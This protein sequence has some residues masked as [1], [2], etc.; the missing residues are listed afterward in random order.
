MMDASKYL[1]RIGFSGST[2]VSL[3]CLAELMACHQ[4]AVPFENLDVFLKR[5]KVLEVEVLFERIVDEQRGGWCCE[6]NGLFAWLLQDLGFTVRRISASNFNPEKKEF[7]MMY[8][9]MALVV[10][11]GE[12]EYLTDVG[13]G[14]IH[15]HYLP[16]RLSENS[17][18]KQPGGLYKLEKDESHWF[19]LHRVRDVVGHHREE[20]NRIMSEETW[21]VV[22]RFDTQAKELEEFQERCDQYQVDSSVMLS[23]MPIC[24]RKAQEGLVVNA[25]TGQRLTTITFKE[26]TDVRT[27]ETD[28]SNA[29]YDKKLKDVFGIN[30]ENPLDIVKIVKHLKKEVDY[31]GT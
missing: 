2:E 16:I 11:L 31:R 13:W 14:N 26:N 20:Q 1:T 21:E 8:H 4:L 22:H 5:K 9:H 6:L 27:N 24:I 10:S 29:E 3:K 15:A 17:V 19:L 23:V 12:Q 30:L 28:L 18:H 25:I 7:R